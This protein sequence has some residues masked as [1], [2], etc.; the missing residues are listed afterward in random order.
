MGPDILNE[1]HLPLELQD[2]LIT[3][4]ADSGAWSLLVAVAETLGH[5]QLAAEFREALARQ[6]D[7]LARV[8]AS[9]GALR[10]PS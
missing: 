5:D 3:G 9:L 7:H 6:E 2:I 1:K 10:E 8:R 4:L